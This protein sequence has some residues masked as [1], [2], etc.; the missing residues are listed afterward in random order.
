MN[1]IFISD[2]TKFKV[3]RIKKYPAGVSLIGKANNI[4][5]INKILY[6]CFCSDGSIEIGRRVSF[7]LVS[8]LVVYLLWEI[9]KRA[10]SSFVQEIE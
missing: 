8:F 10:Y 6:Q 3:R 7:V 1:K 5:N 9:F 2:S 4:T